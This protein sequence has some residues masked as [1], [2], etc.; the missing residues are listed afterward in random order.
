MAQA[1]LTDEGE[2]VFGG[3][4]AVALVGFGKLITAQHQP[5]AQRVKNKRHDNGLDDRGHLGIV[6]VIPAE[7]QCKGGG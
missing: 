1:A 2:G 7:V 4:V 3:A 6:Q 5:D